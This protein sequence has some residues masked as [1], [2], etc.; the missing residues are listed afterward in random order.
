[1]TLSFSAHEQY[2]NGLQYVHDM[3]HQKKD[4]LF[5]NLNVQLGG[6]SITTRNLWRQ[7]PTNLMEGEN[8]RVTWIYL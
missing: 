6:I 7:V 3:V 8:Y 2:T 1:M 4:K 5:H